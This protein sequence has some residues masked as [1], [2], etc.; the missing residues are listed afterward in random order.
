METGHTPV[1]GAAPPHLWRRIKAVFHEAVD[2]PIDRRAEFLETACAGDAELRSMVESLLASDESAKSF[3]EIPAAAALSPGRSPS[4]VS[5]DRQSG[6]LDIGLNRGP[7]NHDIQELLHRRLRIASTIGLGVIGVFYAMRFLR[8]D[9]TRSV[10]WFTMAPGALY[11]AVLAAMSA[12]L[13]RKR[14]YTLPRLRAWEGIIFGMS[15][16]YLLGETYTALFLSPAWFPAYVARHPSE[17]SILARQSSIIWT[18][19]IVLYGT[20]IPNTGRRCAAVVGSMALCPV[21]LVTVG[22]IAAS[23]PTRS[24]LLFLSE[25]VMWMGCAVAMSIYGSHKIAVLREEALAAR[26][27]GPYQL[28]QRLGHGGMGDVYLAEHVL[29]RR[30][31]AV[32]VIRREQAGDAHTL[33]R[34]LREVQVTATLTH[35]NTVQVFDYGQADDGTVYYAMEYLTGLNLEELVSRYGPLPA[36]RLIVV[37]RQLC[38][39]L[40]EAHAVGLIHRDIKPS[41]VILCNRG[42]AYDVAKLLDFGL[43]RSRALDAAGPGLTLAGRIFGTP[44]YMSPEQAAGTPELDARSDVYSL[45]AVAYFML[46]GVPPF[47]RGS[48]VQTL[49]AHINDAVVPLNLRGAERTADLELLVLRCLAKN[50]DDR[51]PDM[52]TLERALGLC[53]VANEWT[54]ASAA[55]WWNA[56]PLS[57]DA[58]ESGRVATVAAG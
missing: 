32:K 44:D 47:A 22:G 4:T 40:A 50:P 34:F 51:F 37:L 55:S 49:A 11:L 31:C 14:V 19:F 3:I 28:K 57:A 38:G 45:G 20:F 12:L 43:V 56:G 23:I 5:R 9:F 42:G 18:V 10:I 53:V 24:L 25:M 6:W 2:L 16:V 7:Q 35:P 26:K 33:Q 30:P 36:P 1:I 13:W 15:V 52:N 46:A 17:M 54:Q 58:V 21:V 29:L 48:V 41:N 27:L 8:L 39:A